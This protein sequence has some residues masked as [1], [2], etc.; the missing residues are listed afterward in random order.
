[1]GTDPVKVNKRKEEK[2][3]Q[4]QTS[5]KFIPGQPFFLLEETKIPFVSQVTWIEA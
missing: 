3:K 2:S 4:L 1:M 5:V